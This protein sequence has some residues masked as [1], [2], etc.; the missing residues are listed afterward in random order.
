MQT[1]G[2]QEGAKIRK[3]TQGADFFSPREEEGWQL[4]RT[5]F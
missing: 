5:Q 4:S 1:L 3:V 2:C